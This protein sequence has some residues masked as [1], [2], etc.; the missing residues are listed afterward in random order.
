MDELFFS[1][2]NLTNN[3]IY[4]YFIDN[5]HTIDHQ[6]ILFGL[7]E[8]NSTEANNFCWNISIKTY[9]PIITDRFE[10]TWWKSM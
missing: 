9:L 4:R 3:N 7:R 5:Q 1:P 6:S 2:F 10:F 8:L